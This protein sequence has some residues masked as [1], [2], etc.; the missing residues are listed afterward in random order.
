VE[1]STYL[2]LCKPLWGWN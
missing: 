2:L 1:S